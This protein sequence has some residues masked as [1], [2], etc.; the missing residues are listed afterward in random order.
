MRYSMPRAYLLLLAV[1]ALLPFAQPAA[2]APPPQ[3][4]RSLDEFKHFRIASIDLLGRMP[5]LD[6]IAAFERSDFDADAWIGKHLGGPAYVE[7][8]TRIYMDLLRLEPNL[9]FTPQQA[10]LHRIEIQGPD[11]KGLYVY[12]RQ[13]Q[14]RVRE[15]TDGE[16]CLTAEETGLTLVRPGAPLT[17]TAKKIDKKVLDAHTVVVKPWWLYRDY[18]SPHPTQRYQMGWNDPD[19]QYRPVDSLLVDPGPDKKPTM[20]IRVCKEEAQALDVGH[21]YA[22]GRTKNP[23]A[24]TKLPGGRT[25]PAPLDKPYATQHKGESIACDTRGAAES[26]VDCGCGVAL[27]RCIPNDAT[28][29]GGA[30]F[31]PNHMPLG[32]EQPLDSVRQNAE[33]WYPY[34]W[35]R[36]AVRY[37]GYI[38]D[39]DRDFREILTG[40]ATMVNGPL[41]QFYRTVQRT[42]CCGPEASFGMTEESAPLFDPHAVP[43]DLMPHDVSRWRLVDDRGPRASGILTMPMFLEKYAT[44]RARGAALYTTFLCKSFVSDGAQLMPSEEPNL[45]KRPGCQ[46]CHATLEP[47][48]AYFARVEPGSFVFLPQSQFPVVNT[49]CKKDKNG[50]LNGPC[51]ALYDVAFTDTNGATLRSA[52]GSPEHADAAPAGAGQDITKMPEFAQCAVQRVASSFLGRQTTSDDAALLASLTDEFVKS[53]FRMRTL[54]R[55]IMRSRAYRN[56]NNVGGT[57]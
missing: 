14:R 28:N 8:L 24:G 46:T 35:S 56:A 3:A 38:F 31:F 12:F 41:A 47:L 43:N 11:G 15:E 22:S 9:N 34:W 17:G 45:M 53:G 19:P 52:Y 54:V 16:F 5:T 44:P 2:S 20:E 36:E 42:S 13:N 57:P 4:A 48:A 27:E 29:E 26:S 51:N 10:E 7:R 50:K 55:G 40:R 6:E 18:K 39:S 30:F 37:V 21:I 32:P 33:R 23:P 49:T 1:A 25:K